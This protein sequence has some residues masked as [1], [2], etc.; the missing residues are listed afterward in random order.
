MTFRYFSI[1]DS[2]ERDRPLGLFAVNRDKEAGRLDTVSYSHSERRW[3]VNPGITRYLFTEAMED[4]AEISRDRAQQIA[5]D[6]RIPLPSEEEM[7]ALTD[8]AERQ[9]AQRRGDG[10]TS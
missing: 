5:R 1:S 4:A 8:E 10:G 3:V 2:D 9:A 7:M 6:L